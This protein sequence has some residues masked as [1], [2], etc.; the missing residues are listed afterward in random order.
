[1]FDWAQYLELARTILARPIP[2]WEAWPEEACFRAAAS[3]AYYA[4]FHAARTTIERE[5]DM[6]F[7]RDRIHREVLQRLQERV[8]RDSAARALK[9]LYGKRLHADYNA[10]RRF[11]SRDADLAIEFASDVLRGLAAE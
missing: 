11:A 3:R 7:G 9:R 8:D 6:T 10:E 5:N 2:P 1:M 4:A